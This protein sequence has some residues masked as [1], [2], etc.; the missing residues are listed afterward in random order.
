M[1][2]NVDNLGH[3]PVSSEPVGRVKMARES[4]PGD[5]EVVES[6]SIGVKIA[7]GLIMLILM[8]ISMVVIL[9]SAFQVVPP[10]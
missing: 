2:E 7:A 9:S 3:S 6:A 1:A 10:T 8:V 4:L 5:E